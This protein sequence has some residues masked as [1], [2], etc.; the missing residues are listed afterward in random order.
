[1]IFPAYIP[2]QNVIFLDGAGILG[3]RQLTDGVKFK[4]NTPTL[5][6]SIGKIYAKTCLKLGKAIC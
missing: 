3:P 4:K 5:I 6:S 2:H 1:M